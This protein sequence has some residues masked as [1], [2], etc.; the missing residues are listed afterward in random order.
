MT[1]PRLLS[2]PE[3]CAFLR[4]SRTVMYALMQRGE[5]PSL[6]IGRSRRIRLDALVAFVE[7][8]SG[9]LRPDQ[10]DQN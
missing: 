7:R 3:A 8:L 9:T 4:V 5:L 6:T 1:P 10:A 2:V